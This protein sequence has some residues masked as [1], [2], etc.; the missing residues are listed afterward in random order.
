MTSATG[1]A[2]VGGGVAA[3][4]TLFARCRA[5]GRAALVGY[6]PAGFPTVPAAVEALRAMVEAGVDVVEVGIPYSDPLLEGPVIAAAHETALAGGTRTA[7]VL[8]TVRAVAETGAPTLVMGYWNP[9]HRYGFR[10]WAAD[11]VS[12]THLTLPTKRIV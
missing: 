11:P 2:V 5:E 12:Y 7:D 8:D 3:L 10:R 6:L 4:D 9:V 1:P